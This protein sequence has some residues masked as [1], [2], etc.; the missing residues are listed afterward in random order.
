[1]N[2]SKKEIHVI[3]D[4]ECIDNKQLYAYIYKSVHLVAKLKKD[5]TIAFLKTNTNNKELIFHPMWL[6]QMLV[7][8]DRKPFPPKQSSIN[9]FIDAVSGYRGLLTSDMRISRHIVDESKVISPKIKAAYEVEKYIQDVQRTQINRSY[10]LKKPKHRIIHYS[11]V[12]LPLWKID[13][14]SDYVSNPLFLNANTGES[15]KYLSSQWETNRWLK[16]K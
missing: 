16:V 5:V 1:M 14:N 6:A 13:I 4:N 11:L 10:I 7:I 12:Y 9:C 3:G 15:E 8:A 2:L